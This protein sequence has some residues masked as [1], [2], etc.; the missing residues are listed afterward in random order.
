MSSKEKTRNADE[1]FETGSEGSAARGKD[2]RRNAPRSTH[3]DWAPASDRPNPVAVLE[4]Q[5]ADRVQELVPL[6]Y[7]RMLVSPFTFYRGAA[8]IMAADLGVTPQ[9]AI[10]AQLCGD[11]HLSNFGG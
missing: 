4:G 8:A 1:A 10:Q 2:A 11:A 6:S 7:G 5:A 3:A 9:T